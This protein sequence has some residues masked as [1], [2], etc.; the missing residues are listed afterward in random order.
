MTIPV[1]STAPPVDYAH[2]YRYG[3]RY[4]KRPGTNGEDVYDQVPLTLEDVLHPLEGDVIPENTVHRPEGDYIRRACQSR[5]RSVAGV[6][7]TSDCL[8]DWDHPTIRSM[9]PDVAVIFN[10]ADPSLPRGTFYTAQEGTRPS[11]VV[12]IV[13][14]HTRTNDITKIDL[15]YQVQVPEYVMIDQEREDGPRSLIHCRWE[16]TG[17]VVTV[18]DQ[19]GVVLQAAHVRLRLRD[20][21]VVCF[22]ATTNEEILDY[23]D[24]E[25][26]RDELQEALDEAERRVRDLEAEL[27][28]LRGEPPG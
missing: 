18:G 11:A 28:R 1:A 19:N 12:E 22:D 26:N 5:L 10:V 9:S 23:L 24:L 6:L 13:S 17:W 21:R 15:Y 3:Y 20:N 2:L 7:V 27:R 16:P 4:V 25:E 14:P 8:I